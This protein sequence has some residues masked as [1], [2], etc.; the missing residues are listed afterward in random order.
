MA[1]DRPAWSAS[2]R[3]ED[4]STIERLALVPRT[5]RRALLGYLKD[6]SLALLAVAW[7]LWM[8]KG[9]T[10]PG[11]RWRI[12][13]LLAGRGYGKTRA[14]AEWLHHVAEEA[15]LRI[16]L[17][18]PTEDEVRSVMIEGA[19]GLLACAPP[20]GRPEWEPSKGIVTWPSGSRAFVYSGANR[21]AARNM[22]MPGA[23]SSPNGPIPTPAGTI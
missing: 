1:I 18:G 16:A 23:T 21:C 13:L 2:W 15:G 6:E 4:L 17:V 10:P 9:Q 7:C 5:Q 14:G 8:R 11:G 12:W 19:S 3:Y 20:E 22:I